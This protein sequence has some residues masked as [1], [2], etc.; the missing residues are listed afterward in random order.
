[1]IKKW[2]KRTAL[3]VGALLVFAIP[4]QAV[5]YEVEIFMAPNTVSLS[6][7][8]GINNN[9]DAVGMIDYKYGYV[10]HLDGSFDI[11]IPSTGD[12]NFNPRGINSSGTVV[13]STIVPG[14]HTRGFIL[15]NGAYSYHRPCTS[16]SCSTW[17]HDIAEDGTVVGYYVGTYAFWYKNSVWTPFSHPSAAGSTY[18]Y[19]VSNDGVV[20]VGE[21]VDSNSVWHPY[22]YDG[23]TF[24]NLPE[25][26]GM[27]YTRYMDINVN[28][29][30][31]GFYVDYNFNTYSF[32]Y[33]TNTGVMDGLP[34]TLPGKYTAYSI[35]DN[36]DVAGMYDDTAGKK[37]GF[38]M[39][40][41]VEPPPPPPTELSIDINN[42]KLVKDISNNLATIR[43][44]AHGTALPETLEALPD[45]S[46]LESVTIT[47]TLPGLGEGGTDLVLTDT[48]DV[49]VKSKPTT[50]Q[51]NK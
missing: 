20:I 47:V 46:T 38:V 15:E 24:T 27:K 35:N 32:T 11:I 5:D 33:D 45:G 14:T 37:Y 8:Q 10:R 41:A 25:V 30:A 28:G 26:P 18:A 40:V 36:G 23:A 1:M 9:G 39:R 7:A 19:G 42:F 21:Y 12:V 34:T 43:V 4:A 51:L 13:G 2:F 49:I 29:I 48:I 31:C 22:M 17:F 3:I 16:G 50:V 6:P 44:V